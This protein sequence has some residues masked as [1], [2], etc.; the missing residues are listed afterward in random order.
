MAPVGD[1]A[2]FDADFNP[3]SHRMLRIWNEFWDLYLF[4]DESRRREQQRRR[5]RVPDISRAL[6]SNSIFHRDITEPARPLPVPSLEV[7]ALE[8]MVECSTPCRA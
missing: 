1:Y 6:Y 3:E 2:V 7:R 4:D 8:N 5:M